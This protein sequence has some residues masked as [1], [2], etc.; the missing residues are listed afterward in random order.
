MKPFM[1][2]PGGKARLAP[3]IWERLCARGVPHDYW[4]PMVGAGAVALAAPAGVRLR[5][6][7]A[8]DDVMALWEM[9]RDDPAALSD[10]LENS[11]HGRMPNDEEGL[12]RYARDLRAVYNENPDPRLGLLLRGLAFNGLWRVN[13]RGELNT[14]FDPARIRRLWNGNP[15]YAN[16]RHLAEVSVYLAAR[17][18]V[19]FRGGID[20]LERRLEQDQT[21]LEGHAF[22]FDPP[23][24]GG[25]TA[26]TAG[27]FTQ[28]DQAGV[29]WL[30]RRLAE[31]GARV[32]YSNANTP[33]IH[34]LLLEH[35]PGGE[36]EGVDNHRSISRDGAK[37]GSVR[38]LLVHT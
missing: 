35:W 5:L 33:L 31:R 23:Y 26:Y 8:C 20:A 3:L 29:L 11:D 14:T 13:A 15:P 18:T 16:R 19:L 10:W 2:Y 22:Y 30:C 27:G 17:Q 24:D 25:H 12:K 9:V 28:D 1:R 21:S 34:A 4:E 36:V 38:E 6:S 32:V 7:D 37:R